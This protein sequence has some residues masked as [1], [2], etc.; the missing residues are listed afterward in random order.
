M[1]EILGVGQTSLNLLIKKETGFSPGQYL[2]HLRINAA[3]EMLI[4][5]DQSITE[6]A[7][8]C[9]FCS[10]QHFSNTF[11]QKTGYSPSE[12]VRENT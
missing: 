8:A 3:R 6:I 10:S 12:F 1:A 7:F 9:G 4:R 2:I 5:S 11:R